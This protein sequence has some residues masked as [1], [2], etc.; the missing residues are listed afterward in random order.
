MDSS[1]RLPPGE[2]AAAGV[3]SRG[4]VAALPGA[5]R[6]RWSDGLVNDVRARRIRKARG[7]VA[8]VATS[9]V[10]VLLSALF[11]APSA[12]GAVTPGSPQQPSGGE[13][14]ASDRVAIAVVTIVV[15]GAVI[16]ASWG[17]SAFRA[18]RR[19]RKAAD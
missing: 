6:R 12:W 19:E 7:D 13:Q 10:A 8:V 15:A 2:G 3:N 18:R 5:G 17:L 11:A 14:S 1:R 9:L 4:V 16:F